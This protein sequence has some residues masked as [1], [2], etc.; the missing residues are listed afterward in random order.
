MTASPSSATTSTATPI[1]FSSS[2]I[3]A[4]PRSRLGRPFC[5]SSVKRA[6][7]VVRVLEQAVAV[8]IGE[9]DRREQ[10]PC[11]AAG[12]CGV[13]GSAGP[14]TISG[15]PAFPGRRPARPRRET[16]C[17]RTALRSTASEIARRSS[18]RCSHGARGRRPKAPGFRLNQRAVGVAATRRGR[19]ASRA[20]R[21][22]RVSRRVG[23]GRDL[24]RRHVELPGLE[25]QQ[26]GVL[27]RDDLDDDAIEV[28]QR[29]AVRGFARSSAGCAR[30]P[31]AA[32]ACTRRG[33]TV[34]GRRAP[35]AASTDPTL[36]RSCR[37]AARASSL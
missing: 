15:S 23:V 3:T 2:R 21:R 10:L 29:R 36:W 35:T 4:A 27:I 13:F 11:A 12:S 37:S 1:F 24:A 25:T 33:R 16:P 31:A 8:A 9:A 18:S 32:P 17:R 19:T 14:D 5:V 7:R 20:L 34:R 30:T 6:G 26:L 22:R 28:R